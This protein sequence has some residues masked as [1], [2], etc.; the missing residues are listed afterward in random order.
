MNVDREKKEEGN[1]QYS[2]DDPREP[3][4]PGQDMQHNLEVFAV[5]LGQPPGAQLRYVSKDVAIGYLQPMW[6]DRAVGIKYLK[7]DECLTG[8]YK[9]R[10]VIPIVTL[11]TGQGCC[12]I[13]AVVEEGEEGEEE[14]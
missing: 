10:S 12:R 13:G 9:D 8:C 6:R 7:D 11:D 2:A 1:N 3:G 14:S 5:Q 4:E